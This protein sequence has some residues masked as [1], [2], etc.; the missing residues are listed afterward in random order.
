MCSSCLKEK[1][2]RKRRE[3]T[4]FLVLVRARVSERVRVGVRVE[5]VCERAV[6]SCVRLW[7]VRA[8]VFVCVFACA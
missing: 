7:C 1:I 6:C 3:K 2:N 5:Y 4:V 8:C